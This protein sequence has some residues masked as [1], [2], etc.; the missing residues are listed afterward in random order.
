MENWEKSEENVIL[1]RSLKFAVRIVKLH[2]YL[3]SKFKIYS[4]SDQL[5]E[6]KRLSG[7]LKSRD[8]LDN[9]GLKKVLFTDGL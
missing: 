9:M 6:L 8:I 4:L 2:R 7:L 5:L 1:D 3:N